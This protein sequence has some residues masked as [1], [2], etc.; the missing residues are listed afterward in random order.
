MVIS[1]STRPVRHP[2]RISGKAAGSTIRTMRCGA[3]RPIAAPDHSIFS[4]TALAP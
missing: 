3:E 1:A 2:V 4:S